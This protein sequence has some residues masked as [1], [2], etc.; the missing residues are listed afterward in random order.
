M[1]RN[2]RCAASIYQC[3]SASFLFDGLPGTAQERVDDDVARFCCKIYSTSEST[4]KD[5]SYTFLSLS[6]ADAHAVFR[7]DFFIH[8]FADFWHSRGPHAIEFT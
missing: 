8:C 1:L 2:K 7:R 5:I 6:I 4:R 3:E